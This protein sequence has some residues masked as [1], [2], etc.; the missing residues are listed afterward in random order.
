MATA[1]TVDQFCSVHVVKYRNFY[2]PLLKKYVFMKG[3]YTILDR[4][5]HHALTLITKE[6]SG[7]GIDYCIIGGGAV[8]I[9]V[10]SAAQDIEALRDRLRRTGDIDT[11]VNAPLEEMVLLFNELTAQGVAS[12]RGFG[13]AFIGGVSIN[14]MPKGYLQGFSHE[15]AFGETEYKDVRGT[16]VNVQAPEICI[17]AKLTGSFQLKDIQDIRLLHRE[18]GGKLDESKIRHALPQLGQEGK[19]DVYHGIIGD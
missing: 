5:Y 7:R 17:A 12:N 18:L 14:Y 16:Q 6:L 3:K 2:K 4:E 13:K 8:Q 9:H 15:F 10:V 11:I 19:M 1:W